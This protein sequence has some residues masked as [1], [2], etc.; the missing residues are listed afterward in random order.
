MPDRYCDG[1]LNYH[2]RPT[3]LR[4]CQGRPQPSAPG[5]SSFRC[6]ATGVCEREL[7]IASQSERFLDSFSRRD[8][9]PTRRFI[10]HE[11]ATR[12]GLGPLRLQ[13]TN[14][15]VKSELGS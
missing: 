3:P 4:C 7:F 14:P 9:H 2:Q 13:E 15:T 6:G 10:A 11:L 1:G 8:C 12:W 5:C